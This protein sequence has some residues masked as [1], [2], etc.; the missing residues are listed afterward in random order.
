MTM[1]ATM[2]EEFSLDEAYGSPPPSPPLRD[3]MRVPAEVQAFRDQERVRYLQ[4]ELETT[5]DPASQS[6]LRREIGREGATPTTKAPRATAPANEEEFSLDEAYGG[7]VDDPLSAESMAKGNREEFFD[8]VTGAPLRII[9]GTAANLAGVG[10]LILGIPGQLIG[11]GAGLGMSARAIG[12]GKSRRESAQAFT[13]ANQIVQEK[14]SAPIL[15]KLLSLVTG[16]E[17]SGVGTAMEKIEALIKAGGAKVEA[18]T[19]GRILAE[20]V[21]NLTSVAMAAGGGRGLA[22]GLEKLASPK[23]L[24]RAGFTQKELSRGVETEERVPPAPPPERGPSPQPFTQGSPLTADQVNSSLGIRPAGEVT[25]DAKVRRAQTQA[26]FRENPGEADYLEW[27]ADERIAR[28]QAYAAER[29]TAEAQA[30]EAEAIGSGVG[31]P[32]TGLSEGTALDAPSRALSPGSTGI[33]TGAALDSGLAKLREGR[34]FE[35]S[36]EEKIALRNSGPT[37]EILGAEGAPLNRGMGRGQRG[38]VDFSFSNRRAADLVAEENAS[39]KEMAAAA[40]GHESRAA[41]EYLS[42]D[43]GKFF[44]DNKYLLEKVQKLQDLQPYI[45]DSQLWSDAGASI[46]KLGDAFRRFQTAIDDPTAAPLEAINIRYLLGE[47]DHKAIL[48]KY[49]IAVQEARK[50]MSRRGSQRSMV[51]GIDEALGNVTKLKKQSGGADPDL[52]SR[53]GVAGA[54]AAMGAYLGDEDRGIGALMGGLAGGLLGPKGLKSAARGADYG[55]GSLSTRIRN[56]SPA[57]ALRGRNYERAVLG[58]THD[59]IA[60]VDPFLVKLN[61]LPDRAKVELNRALTSNE[62]QAISSVLA[63]AP[64]L[65]AAW[66]AVQAVLADTRAAL[67][68]H[69][70]L[71]KGLDDYFPRIVKDREGLLNALGSAAK[72]DLEK[73]IAVAETR[74]GRSLDPIEESI[75]VNRYLQGK[76]VVGEGKP[77]FSKSRTVAQVTDQLAPF[78]ASPTEA[79]HTYLSAANRAIE[80]AKFFG[81]DLVKDG[82]QINVDASIGK[83]VAREM[84]AGHLDA[85]GAESLRSMIIS[86]FGPGETLTAKPIQNL[87][88]WAYA[89]LLGNPISAI[90]QLGDVA[91]VAG[92]MG[93]RPTLMAVA[94]KLMRKPGIG[95]K[96]FGLVDHISEEFFNTPNSAKFLNHALKYSGFALMDTFGKDVALRAAR[97]KYEK[98]AKSAAGEKSIA[99][100]YQAAYGAE[101]PQL[102]ADLK[103]GKLTDSTRSLLFSE[104]SDIQPISKFEMPQ[105]YLDNPNGRT[106]YMLKT[107]ALKQADIVRRESYDEIKKGNV[108]KGLGNLTKWALIF[109]LAGMTTSAVQ[110]WLLGRKVKVDEGAFVENFFRT[111][112]WSHYV[113]DNVRDGKVKDAVANMVM[114]PFDML[115]SII[116]RDPKA[117]QYIPI[118]GKLLYNKGMGGAEKADKGEAAA[119]KRRARRGQKKGPG[120]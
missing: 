52:L 39:A 78:Y 5:A 71:E 94:E 119:D 102:V 31:E 27:K 2:N 76:S 34:G 22:A 72:G 97:I 7:K 57:I 89:G 109:G 74:L 114:P 42:Q 9:K 87:K 8:R 80:K 14:L 40:L 45:Q 93:L 92:V 26:A 38:A 60:K 15:G 82:K 17:G 50:G 75:E 108:A 47:M 67:Q 61:E 56:L 105:A 10:D 116:R 113:A 62:P 36:A 120:L 30:R 59:A 106:L 66:P 20:E 18:L 13:D 69:G 3:S 23:G 86:R 25:A 53:L 112:G 117:A 44:N 1:E 35:L 101:F 98:L 95:V 6:A 19:G 110:D 54:G 29:A 103:S 77:G 46:T 51:D 63:Q 85:A 55:L 65:R 12:S 90:S 4:R 28:E 107:W 43:A 64:K 100:K 32:R 91:T 49:V 104:L 70:L 115:S 99:R 33:Y 16:E 81:R 88:N 24:E 21:E 58:K 37:P 68:Q 83:M 11:V 79:L 48:S 111:F 96:D 73:R 84:A 41:W 118:V